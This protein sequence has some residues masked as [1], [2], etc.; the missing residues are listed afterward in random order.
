[1]KKTKVTAERLAQMFGKALPQIIH[2]WIKLIFSKC[3]RGEC[4][5][6]LWK[7]RKA[8]DVGTLTKTILITFQFDVTSIHIVEEFG[9]ILYWMAQPRRSFWFGWLQKGVHIESKG[10][11]PSNSRYSHDV[12]KIQTNNLPIL[13][14]ER[15][16]ISASGHTDADQLGT[17]FF[18]FRWRSDPILSVP[19]ERESATGLKFLSGQLTKVIKNIWQLK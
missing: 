13:L 3:F 7:A 6:Q 15:V 18:R 19:N 12:T 8:D 14:R 9:S 5:C 4:M 17:D 10:K 16:Q 2:L 1:M 11:C